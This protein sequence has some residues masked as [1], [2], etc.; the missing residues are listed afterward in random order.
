VRD[1]NAASSGRDVEARKRMS[2]DLP[3]MSYSSIARGLVISRK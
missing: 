3:K 2:E 1:G